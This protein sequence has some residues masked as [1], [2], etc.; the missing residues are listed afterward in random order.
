MMPVVIITRLQEEFATEPEPAHRTTK[1]VG[2]EIFFT[3]QIESA[4]NYSLAVII[5]DIKKDISI[6]ARVHSFCAATHR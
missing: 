2:C 3:S 6:G 5:A 1:I 4:T